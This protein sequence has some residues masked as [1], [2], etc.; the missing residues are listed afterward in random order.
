MFSHVSFIELR[1]AVFVFFLSFIGQK[2]SFST[3]TLAYLPVNPNVQSAFEVRWTLTIT[4]CNLRLF[5]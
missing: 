1:I 4:S 5:E 3:S 2:I